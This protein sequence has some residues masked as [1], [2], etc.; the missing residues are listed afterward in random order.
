MLITSLGQSEARWS[1]QNL[2]LILCQE[3]GGEGP[4]KIM[5]QFNIVKFSSLLV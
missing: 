4:N 5:N 2:A 3:Q 1:D